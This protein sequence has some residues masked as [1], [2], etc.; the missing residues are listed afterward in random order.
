M[1]IA[2]NKVMFERESA[3][4]FLSS[5]FETSFDQLLYNEKRKSIEKVSAKMPKN[6]GCHNGNSRASFIRG[7]VRSPYHL[8]ATIPSSFSARP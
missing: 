2:L 3:I 4:Y 6:S 7:D 1:K 8:E 5:Q